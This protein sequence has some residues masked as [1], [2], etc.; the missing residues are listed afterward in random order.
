MSVA[1]RK[2]MATVS[3]AWPAVRSV[4]SPIR[5]EKQFKRIQVLVDALLDEG[6]EED[7]I[8]TLTTLMHAFEEEHHPLPSVRGR[9][10]LAFL[11]R[12]HHLKQGDLAK[13]LGSQSVVSE[14]LNGKRDLNVRQIRTLARRFGVSSAVFVDED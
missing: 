6:A 5:S 14:V 10:A 7:L 4:L 9:V 11:M 2:D 3:K 1:T 8:D 12:E 13:E